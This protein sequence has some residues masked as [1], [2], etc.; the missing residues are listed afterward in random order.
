MKNIWG[1]IFLSI[2]CS[3]LNGMQENIITKKV[4]EVIRSVYKKPINEKKEDDFSINIKEALRL[5]N[6]HFQFFHN[7]Y[8]LES[9]RGDDFR[10]ALLKKL[11]SNIDREVK[12]YRI[13]TCKKRDVVCRGFLQDTEIEISVAKPIDN[14]SK[15]YTLSLVTQLKYN[16]HK[17]VLCTIRETK[18]NGKGW[19]AKELCRVIDNII[20]DTRADDAF[21]DE[22]Y[23][24]RH[25]LYGYE[26]ISSNE[27][28]AFFTLPYLTN[29]S[30]GGI[31]PITFATSA[32]VE[33]WKEANSN[34]GKWRTICVLEHPEYSHINNGRIEVLLEYDDYKKRWQTV[35]DQMKNVKALS[36]LSK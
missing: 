36:E 16:K 5:A 30:V 13:Y 10:F 9:I 31:S 1:V 21:L 4:D 8:A 33:W 17:E 14:T 20:L 3:V 22:Q 23:G 29:S 6:K 15:L 12:A 32:H 24:T 11:L 18:K 2:T 27:E 34:E 28:D 7:T 25:Y 35:N 26:N 19:N